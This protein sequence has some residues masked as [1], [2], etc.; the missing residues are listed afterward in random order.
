M[1]PPRNRCTF[2][3]G[4]VL[5]RVAFPFFLF[6]FFVVF[7]FLFLVGFL[8]LFETQSFTLSRSPT[9]TSSQRSPVLSRTVLWARCAALKERCP[10]RQKS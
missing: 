7:L 3:G 6:V 8:L 2:R 1:S 5:V 10:P 9:H 4:V